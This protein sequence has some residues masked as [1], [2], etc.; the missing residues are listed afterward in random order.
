MNVKNVDTYA[1]SQKQQFKMY[2]K[3][4]HEDILFCDECEYGF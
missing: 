1:T 4:V 2:I 3:S